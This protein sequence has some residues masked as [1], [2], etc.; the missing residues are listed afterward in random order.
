L[1]LCN[2][3]STFT[4][5]LFRYLAKPGPALVPAPIGIWGSH[6]LVIDN[7]SSNSVEGS[8]ERPSNADSPL[9]AGGR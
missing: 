3:P 2:F 8:L 7:A 4:T 6:R 5:S 1:R 9:V